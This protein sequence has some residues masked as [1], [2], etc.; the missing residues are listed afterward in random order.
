MMWVRLGKHG[1]LTKW[2]A[3]DGSR[4]VYTTHRGPPRF[5]ADKTAKSSIINTIPA[6][7]LSAVLLSAPSTADPAVYVARLRRCLAADCKLIHRVDGRILCVGRGRRC[8]WLGKWAQFLAGE[9][10]CPHWEAIA[11]ADA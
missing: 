8:E 10:D 7:P 3:S 6:C 4:F 11:S 5:T 9:E 2:R 1:K